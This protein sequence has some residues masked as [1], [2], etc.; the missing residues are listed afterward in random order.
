METQKNGVVCKFHRFSGEIVE[1]IPTAQHYRII[2]VDDHAL[3]RHAIKRII[4]KAP[5]LKVVGEAGDGYEALELLKEIFPDL[6]ILD[7]SMPRCGGLETSRE[8]KKLY[9]GLKVIILTMHRDPGYME[10]ALNIGV[11]GYMLKEAV[12]DELIEAI[13][14]LKEGKTYFPPIKSKHK[15]TEPAGHNVF[16]GGRYE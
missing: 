8:I 16:G 12:A 5:N 4:E 7:I 1:R 13:S 14:T 11:D 10:C 9:P 2:L 15:P 6:V 3:F